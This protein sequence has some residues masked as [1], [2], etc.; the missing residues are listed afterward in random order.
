MK[1]AGGYKA[2]NLEVTAPFDGDI[3]AVI[4]NE[5]DESLECIKIWGQR[6]VKRKRFYRA[7]D[8]RN[9]GSIKAYDIHK[10]PH[11]FHVLDVVECYRRKEAS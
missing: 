2:V 8:V 5:Y 7:A 1:G 6:F 4:E 3:V 10:K 11:W 9:S